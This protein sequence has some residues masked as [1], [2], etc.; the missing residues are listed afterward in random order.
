MPRSGTIP[1]IP[2]DRHSKIGVDNLAVDEFD[3]ADADGSGELSVIE[4]FCLLP[5]VEKR[6][7]QELRALDENEYESDS[8]EYKRIH[9]FASVYVV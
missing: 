9:F 8:G 5:Q 4:M 2:T 1:L 3:K 6:M 7:K